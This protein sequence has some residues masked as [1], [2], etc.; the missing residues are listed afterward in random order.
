MSIGKY[1]QRCR[2]ENIFAQR[3]RSE[4]I[5]KMSI[6]KYTRKMSIGKNTQDV[7]PIQ[8]KKT[9]APSLPSEVFLPSPPLLFSNKKI[10]KCWK[11]GRSNPIRKSTMYFRNSTSLPP[12]F[13]QEIY[14]K[15][16]EKS[17]KVQSENPLCIFE[18]RQVF[19]L[20]FPSSLPLSNKKYTKCWEKSTKVPIR[21]FSHLCFRNSTSLPP[22]NKKCWEKSLCF[23]SW[24]FSKVFFPL[25]YFESV[26]PL[27]YF[28]SVSH[29]VFFFESVFPLGYFRKCF[30]SL[31][32][33]EVHSKC[34]KCS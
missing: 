12:P 32:F 34:S 24:I 14:K 19:L 28:E 6:G 26:F 5:R 23:P 15:C 31:F 2:S 3:C 21:K 17:A 16:W 9:H 33:L 13:Q 1:T 8:K 27:G 7:D 29:F 20:P 10:Y 4:N 22:S 30:P 11:K 18:I 25:G